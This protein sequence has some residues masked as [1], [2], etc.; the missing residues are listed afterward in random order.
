[1]RVG[2]SVGEGRYAFRVTTKPT[3]ATLK[4]HRLQL[5]QFH[6]DTRNLEPIDGYI[7]TGLHFGTTRRRS[8]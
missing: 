1:M 6:T 5:Q 8:L 2:V 3:K 4:T 7:E